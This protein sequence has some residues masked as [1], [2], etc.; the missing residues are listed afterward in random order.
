[1]KTIRLTFLFL[2]L[3]GQTGIAQDTMYFYK[4][5]NV[6]NS[7]VIAFIDSIAFKEAPYISIDM[8]AS[9]STCR[10]GG[11]LSISWKDNVN[12]KVRIDLYKGAAFYLN[13][14]SSTNSDG[15]FDWTLPV[16]LALGNDYNI[17]ISG[18]VNKSLITYSGS[19]S[20]LEESKITVLSPKNAIWSQENSQTISWTDNFDE[21]VKIELYKGSAFLRTIS[22]GVPSAGTFVWTIPN[23][24]AIASDYK[25]RLSSIADPA[26]QAF[27]TSF[28]ISRASS[29][30]NVNKLVGPISIDGNWDKP[31]WSTAEIIPINN[32]M[33]STA[34]IPVAEAKMMYSD[35]NLYV[36]FRIQ[37]RNV[38][39]ITTAING[40]V[41]EDAAAEFFF[42]PDTNTPEKYFN[43]E[44]NCGGTPLMFYSTFPKTSFLEL[45]TND[46]K[47]IEIAHS[48][49]RTVNPEIAD[50][51]TWY[52]EY[53]IPL[54]LIRK[55][56]NL[57]QP[58][59]GVVWRANFYQCASNNSNPRWLTWALI[60][61]GV[62]NFHQPEFFGRLKFQ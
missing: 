33:N 44:M 21:N 12:E 60:K 30:V 10:K 43:L 16:S 56:S 6:I 3:A 4:L 26:V 49:P 22:S 61:N 40:P 51:V 36:I 23:D 59:M 47:Q 25:I 48:M 45:D 50:P 7:Q 15:L 19:F 17:C 1:M 27:S 42:A 8:P 62:L 34:F 54:S 53:R 9:N 35:S 41:W 14:T 58:A 52:L 32:A 28:S 5:G 11:K 24:L 18:T 55:Y 37:D 39:S 46:I 20:I 31:Q 38:R 29:E 13:I 2:V 57:T